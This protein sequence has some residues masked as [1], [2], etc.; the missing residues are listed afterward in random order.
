MNTETIKAIFTNVLFVMGVIL[1]IFGFVQGSLTAVRILTFDRYPLDSYEESRCELDYGF[2]MNR[3][4][5][6]PALTEEQIN[7]RRAECQ[8]TLDRERQVRQSEHIVSALT[9]L[10][11][12]AVLVYSFRR[13]IF[14]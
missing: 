3:G 9:T 12:G 7:Q 4:E 5:E 8:S 11:S 14:K 1:V 2:A 13:F 6:S 10:V